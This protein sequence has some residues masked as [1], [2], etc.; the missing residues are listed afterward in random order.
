MPNKK[1]LS[2]ALHITSFSL[3]ITILIFTEQNPRVLI[4]AHA[5]SLLYRMPTVWYCA[6]YLSR[7][8]LSAFVLGFSRL[9]TPA[10]RGKPFRNEKN[11]EPAG[12]PSYL[13]IILTL[14]FTIAIALSLLQGTT[15]FSPQT[16]V[17]EITLAA[18]VALLFWVDDVFG[19]Q[20]IIDPAKAVYQ[21]LGYNTPPMNF[22]IAALF[23]GTFCLFVPATIAFL[24]T[25]DFPSNLLVDW[26]I[27]VSLSF[28]K[29]IYQLKADFVNPKGFSH[30][31]KQGK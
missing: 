16:F 19:G 17:R 9:P 1:V 15:N 13:M 28:I 20:I 5:V 18:L 21:N 25:A 10:D 12:L 4:Y 22:M 23:I 29:L 6:T 14:I 27:L 3:A 26:A 8:S 11:R 7:T 2:A 31:S 30:L 24:F